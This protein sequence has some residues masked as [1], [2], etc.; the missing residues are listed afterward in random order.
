M[1]RRAIRRFLY[2]ICITKVFVRFVY[3]QFVYS[4]YCYWTLP[5]PEQTTK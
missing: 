3:K 1:K 2:A 4:I 5:G